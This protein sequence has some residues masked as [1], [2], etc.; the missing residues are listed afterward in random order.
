MHRPKPR[1]VPK[2][3][4]VA[5]V[6]STLIG[7]FGLARADDYPNR[8]ITLIV[9]FPPG[10]ST[11]VM[12]RN[13]ADKLAASSGPADRGGESWRC[14]RHPRHPLCGQGRA[15]WLHHFAELYCHDGDRAPP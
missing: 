7:T 9:P 1:S 15:R 6:C 14:G 12:A 13:V 8:P 5:L 11:T 3:T 10:G 4:L 2:L